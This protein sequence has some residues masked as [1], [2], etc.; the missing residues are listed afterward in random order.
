MPKLPK[1]ILEE[2][3]KQAH[4][5]IEKKRRER[6]KY[7]ME[8]LKS[9][10]PESSKQVRLHQV[11]ILENAVNYIK[12]LDGLGEDESQESESTSRTLEDSSCVNSP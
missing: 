9:L 11:E 12:Q 5:V 1:H 10:V 6:I 8:Q 4:S 7:C 2:N 3:R